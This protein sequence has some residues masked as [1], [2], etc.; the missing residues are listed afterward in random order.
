MANRCASRT[1]MSGA[2][3]RASATSA[4]RGSLC[5]CQRRQFKDVAHG[6]SYEV[7]YFNSNGL[8]VPG[9]GPRTRGVGND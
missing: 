9:T 5:D 6:E 7:V 4:S 1:L 3:T 2:A 8:F